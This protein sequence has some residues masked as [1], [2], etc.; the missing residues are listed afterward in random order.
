VIDYLAQRESLNDEIADFIKQQTPGCIR[1]LTEAKPQRN[2]MSIT[3]EI[4]KLTPDKARQLVHDQIK[5]R[6]PSKTRVTQYAE[7]MKRG[8]WALN[9]QGIIVTK[10]GKM[11]D[12][13]HR[14]MAVIES[15]VTIDALLIRGVSD[16]H[17][18]L[19][20]QGKSRSVAD[21][22]GGVANYNKV[23]AGLRILYREHI[24]V[25]ISS[26]TRI[27]PRDG[28]MLLEKHPGIVTS[29]SW[30]AGHQTMRSILTS[31]PAT[32]CHY[33]AGLINAAARDVFFERLADGI[34]LS[35]RS[36]ILGLRNALI[37]S[38]G[39]KFKEQ[40]QLALV[41]RAWRYYRIGKHV[42]FIRYSPGA[43]DAFPAWDA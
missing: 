29:A 3:T 38:N 8:R 4:I 41:I 13:Q 40:H 10:S 5:N 24:G 20:D 37:V 28:R 19:I 21:V 2:S 34:G 14:C 16:A 35:A 32:Y 9:G 33:R 17:F 30:V 22:L 1:G 26:N 6:V 7:E 15:G 11:I 27:T 43:G 36:P 25:S 39:Q 23:A 42:S 12:G 18:D 31:G